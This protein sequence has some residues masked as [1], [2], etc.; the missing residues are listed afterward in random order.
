MRATL[1][2]EAPELF[3]P[4]EDHRSPRQGISMKVL[5]LG[6]S[7]YHPTETRHTTCLMLPE[8]NLVFD[9]G[10]GFFRCIEHL[11]PGRLDLFLT[12]F[13]SD[14]I[15]GLHYL[16]DVIHAA[17]LDEVHIW[18]PE[19]VD[20]AVRNFFK[21]PYFPVP[22]E[23]MP[24]PVTIHDLTRRMSNTVRGTKIKAVLQDHPGGS[25]GYRVERDGK[26]LVFMTDTYANMD[27]VKFAENADLLIH[28]CYFRNI[29]KDR[30]HVTGHSYSDIVGEFAAAAR[31][32]HLALTHINPLDPEP[33]H[34][35]R[36]V[37]EKF[38]DTFIAYDK[39]E[40]NL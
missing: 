29:D 40:I 12:H 18:G 6:T 14:H 26:S 23:K 39:S 2:R 13:H 36:E 32:R 25:L 38:H 22:L 20:K 8:L 28:E 5:F 30:A 9:A 11:R 35:L 17:S 19:G 31:V 37:M 21:K 24:R 4:A 33:E 15:C 7:G 16:I 34:C 3:E 10:T 1:R 27:L